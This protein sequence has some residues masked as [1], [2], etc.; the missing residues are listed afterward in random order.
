MKTDHNIHRL[1]IFTANEDYGQ[2]EYQHI[3]RGLRENKS[4][5]TCVN[6]LITVQV[7]IVLWI[8]HYGFNR[9]WTNFLFHHVNH[10]V[11]ALQERKLTA[12]IYV[13]LPWTSSRYSNLWSLE[14]RLV[15]P[16]QPF[17]LQ[18]SPLTWQNMLGHPPLSL[19]LSYSL[20]PLRYIGR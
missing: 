19:S 7:P 4:V 3:K 20:F 14:I 16:F 13:L 12:R 5:C 17:L 6:Y 11:A 2:H 9:V 1:D 10:S 15:L 8:W 18:T